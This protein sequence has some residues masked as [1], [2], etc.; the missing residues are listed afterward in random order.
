MGM[1]LSGSLNLTGSLNTSGSINLTGSVVLNQLT[2]PTFGFADGQYGVEVPTLGVNNVFSM[3]V[4]KTIYEYVKNDSGAFLAKGT[5]VHSVGTVGFNTLVIAASASV[6]STM[7]ATFILAQDLDDEEEGL[8]IAIGAIQGVDTTGLIAGDPVWVG[9]NGGWTQTKPTGSNL[10]QNLGIVT[11]VGANG[12]G[13]VLGAGRSNDVPNIQ[14]GYFWAGNSGSVA[15]AFPTSSFALT[16]SANTFYGNQTITGSLNITGSITINSGS[17]KMPNRPAFKVIGNGGA[18]RATASP[19]L[20]LSAS[21]LQTPVFNQGNHF[22]PTTGIFTAPIA[23]LYQVNLVVRTENNTNNTIN[24]FIV[25]KS[26]SATAG[27]VT[28][29]MI[30]FGP[31]TSMNHSGG[32]TISY[33]DVGDTL[34]AAL[35]VGSG[36]FD[37]NDNFSVAYIG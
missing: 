15:T 17:I 10:I 34:K 3:G 6:A 2:Y 5:P 28:E 4:P 37:G 19:G 11:K 27:N 1:K 21:L 12:G 29:V 24:Q 18:I 7:P 23:G 13:V 30:E 36:S 31:N 16:S 8:G 14:Q 20:V 32:S 25:Y 35:V 26:G 22:N 9:A 33:L